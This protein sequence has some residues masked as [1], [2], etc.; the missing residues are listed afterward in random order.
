MQKAFTMIEL[1]IVMAVIAIL[2]GIILFS[3]FQYIN[4]GKDSNIA[5]NLSV[6]VPAGE[7]YYNNSGSYEDFCESEIVKNSFSQ[8]PQNPN[9]AWCSVSVSGEKWAACAVKF[10]SSEKAFCVDSR[11]VKKDINSDSCNANITECIIN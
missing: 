7:I 9:G 6:L 3:V 8:M 1:L 11:G 2:S 5:G 4:L 10:S